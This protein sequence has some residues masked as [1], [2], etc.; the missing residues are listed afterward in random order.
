MKRVLPVLLVSVS[1]GVC[2]V[3]RADSWIYEFIEVPPFY[4]LG[5]WY[6]SSL[7]VTPEGMPRVA[8][9]NTGRPAGGR[10]LTYAEKGEAGWSTEFVD[11]THEGDAPSLVLDAS[12]IPHISFSRS[13]GVYYA[14][15]NGGQWVYETINNAG[16]WGTLILCS[17]LA[18]AADGPCVSYTYV[19]NDSLQYSYRDATGWRLKCIDHGTRP[20]G[21][22]SSLAVDPGDVSHVIYSDEEPYELWHATGKDGLPWDYGQIAS[23]AWLGSTAALKCDSSGRLHLCYH[24]PV[25]DTSLYYASRDDSGWH[26]EL[27]D[28]APSSGAQIVLDQS[29]MP[30]ILYYRAGE[31]MYAYKDDAGWHTEN[32]SAGCSYYTFYGGASL[33]V[34]SS[35]R[36]HVS[37]NSQWDLAYLRRWIGLAMDCRGPTGWGRGIKVDVDWSFRKVS[38]VVDV[39]LAIQPPGGGL[40]FVGPGPAL[41][42]QVTPIARRVRVSGDMRGTL[43]LTVGVKPPNG[44]YT[45]MAACVPAGSSVAD[46]S[47]HLG[48]GINK[49]VVSVH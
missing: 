9:C 2:G 18:L 26:R 16:G 21:V 10:L 22:V 23:D 45:F 8:Y 32:V 33:A 37:V 47:T 17:S 29:G 36:P 20:K 3:S 1:L 41:W 48:D 19:E 38:G 44:D 39:Y 4:D 24:A 6:E 46:F 5:H 31:L 49:A 35:G 12:G 34:D 27:V 11:A 42:R 40:L 25:R 15:R 7:A 13:N 30:H 28:G 14:R 43:A